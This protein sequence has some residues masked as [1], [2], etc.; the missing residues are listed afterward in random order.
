MP[1][2]QTDSLHPE[3]CANLEKPMSTTVQPMYHVCVV[4]DQTGVR[5]ITTRY[6]EEHREA[7]IIKNKCIPAT[8]PRRNC[9]VQ[10]RYP[11]DWDHLKLKGQLDNEGTAMIEG[12]TILADQQANLYRLLDTKG[13][14]IGSYKA[15][16][17]SCATILD[18]IAHASAD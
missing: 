14:E 13:N 10:L 11:K 15:N 9:L 2:W 17:H 1:S 3:D 7:C 5:T 8:G 16:V 12:K 6:P 18:L 4:N